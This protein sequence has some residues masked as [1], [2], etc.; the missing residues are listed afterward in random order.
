MKNTNTFVCNI[1]AM[2]PAQKVRYRELTGML[3]ESAQ[4]EDL[5]NG[6][7]LNLPDTLWMQAAEFV[8]FERLCCP[9]LTFQLGLHGN[10]VYLDLCG[11]EGV[12][13]FLQHELGLSAI[14]PP[15]S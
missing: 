11:D 3:K 13:E 12:R 9:F 5:Q 4:V 2:T 1:G 8:T 10:S 15:A 14:S 7:R 6:Y